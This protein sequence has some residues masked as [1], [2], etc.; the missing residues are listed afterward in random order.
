VSYALLC[1]LNQLQHRQIRKSQTVDKVFLGIP[2]MALGED[3][4][5]LGVLKGS[6]AELQKA[7]CFKYWVI[8]VF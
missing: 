2:R 1:D 3:G 6:I 5:W 7:G 4:K 8:T